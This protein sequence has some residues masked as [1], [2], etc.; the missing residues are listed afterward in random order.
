M[1]FFRV[2]AEM[3]GIEA[4]ELSF[5]VE[6]EAYFVINL[7]NSHH[8]YVYDKNWRNYGQAKS[9][10]LDKMVEGKVIIDVWFDKELNTRSFLAAGWFKYIRQLKVNGELIISFDDVLED[11]ENDAHN[12]INQGIILTTLGGFLALIIYIRRLYLKKYELS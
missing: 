1:K 10:I 5:E 6:D 2:S 4:D 8:Q 12:G 11:R 9:I 7:I 3:G